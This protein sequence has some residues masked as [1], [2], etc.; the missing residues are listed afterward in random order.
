MIFISI[1]I[2]AEDT[3]VNVWTLEPAIFLK[4]IRPSPKDRLSRFSDLR[5]VKG[6]W[7]HWWDLE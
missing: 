2:T 7:G 6:F 4:E 1:K 3:Q 5:E